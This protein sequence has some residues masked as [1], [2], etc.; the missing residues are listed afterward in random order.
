MTDPGELPFEQA[1]AELDE[2]VRR[3]EDGSTTLEDALAL[4]VR[5]EALHRRCADILG[6]AEERLRALRPDADPASG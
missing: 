1:R 4:W 2:V 3:L 5:G 6:A